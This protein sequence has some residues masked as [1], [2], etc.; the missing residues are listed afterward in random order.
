LGE[1]VHGLTRTV[2]IIGW[3]VEHS[4]SP[5]IHNAAFAAAGLDWIDVPMPVEPG[6]LP[7]AIEGLR[8]LGFAGAN[9][10][11]PHKTDAAKLMDHLSEDAARLLAVNTIVVEG[12][13]SHGHNTD[14]PGFERFLRLDAGV[15]AAGARALVFG[16]GGA[17]RAV[18]LALA[19]AGAAIV[20]VAARDPGRAR[21]VVELVGDEGTDGEAVA[22]EDAA[23]CEAGLIVNATPLGRGREHLPLPPVGRNS[24][25]IDLLYP[26]VTPLQTAV[27][28]AGGRGFG[29]LGPLVHQA[30]LSFELWTGCKASLDVMRGAAE[31]AIA[32]GSAP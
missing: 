23:R 4:L 31:T 12:G 27:I 26:D 25:G 15:D 11:M 28:E 6:R 14:A 9:V 16:A 3:P 5:A 10:T 32:A 20:T 7:Q 17:A 1:P 22:F 29:G 24:V 30:G 2:G 13:R 18:G 21:T 8:G 19:R